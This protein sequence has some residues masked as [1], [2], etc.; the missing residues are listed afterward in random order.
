MTD[1]ENIS[2]I[3]QERIEHNKTIFNQVKKDINN[4]E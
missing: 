3:Q 1:N 4:N 2:F